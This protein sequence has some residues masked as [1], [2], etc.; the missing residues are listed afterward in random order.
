MKESTQISKKFPGHRGLFIV[1]EGIDRI[2]KTT[3][4]ELLKTYF[5]KEHNIPSEILTFPDRNSE[6]GKILNSLLI[7]KTKLN[8]NSSHLL[9][10]FNRWEKQEEIENLLKKGVNLLVDRYAFSGVI[11]S[12]VQGYPKDRALFADRGLIRPDLVFRMTAKIDYIRNRHNFGKELY[13]KDYILEK[14]NSY[15]NFFNKKIYWNNINAE[16]DISSIHNDVLK[17]V[18]AKI[19]CYFNP[20]Y[21]ILPKKNKIL[22]NGFPYDIGKDLFTHK[23]I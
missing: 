18:K 5:S 7:G 12:M 3:Q 23:L 10:S 2:G 6:S 8:L 17:I 15:Y 21:S 16:R 4:V 14:V 11:Y 13:E 20:T 22:Y 9:F 1:F 19:N